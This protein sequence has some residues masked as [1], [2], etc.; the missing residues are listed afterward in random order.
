MAG[1]RWWRAT[2]LRPPFWPRHRLAPAS[3]AD[4]IVAAARVAPRLDAAALR[5][6]LDALAARH[7]VLRAT[8]VEGE[9]GP[10]QRFVPSL[11]PELVEIDAAGMPEADRRDLALREAYRPF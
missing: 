4:H 6:A 9:E 7:P 3:G 5:R 1:S 8:F 10:R 2:A 11:W